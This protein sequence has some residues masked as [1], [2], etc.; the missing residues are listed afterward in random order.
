[1]H[2]LDLLKKGVIW[3]IGSGSQVRIFRDNWI[4]R[5]DALKVSGRLAN[6]RRRWVS[7]LINPVTRSWDEDD[8]RQ[9]CP[10]RDA[11]AILAIKLPARSCDDFVAWRPEKNGIFSVRS[12]YRLGVEP[13][14]QALSHGQSSSAPIGDRSIWNVIWKAKVPQKLKVFAWK[15][16]TSTLA[17]GT[18]LHRRISHISPIC[19]ICGSEEED[20]HHALIRCTMAKALRFEMR[21]VWSLPPESAFRETGDEWLLHLLGNVSQDMRSQ[22][23]FL[24]WRV[25]HHR[26]DIVHGEG[27]ASIV[28]SASFIANYAESF[29]SASSQQDHKGKSVPPEQHFLRVQL[30][31]QTGRHMGLGDSKLMWMP[32]GIVFL[33][34][35]DWV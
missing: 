9:C 17:V 18:G 31:S 6:S 33:R 23:I 27:K 10:G 2:G 26:N 32:D 7:E 22:L 34:E 28:A 12:A 35:V 21:K 1:M 11:D 29:R 3:R 30:L 15:A 4:P 8:V 24:L 16:A 20:E 5:A 19:S 14:L 13:N 25:W